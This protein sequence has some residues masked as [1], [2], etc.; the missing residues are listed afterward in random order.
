MREER[1]FTLLF[2]KRYRQKRKHKFGISRP[3]TGLSIKG[4]GFLLLDSF[5]EFPFPGAFEFATFS[6]G[7]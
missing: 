3:D 5:N 7:N 4:R 2:H 6:I 1:Y